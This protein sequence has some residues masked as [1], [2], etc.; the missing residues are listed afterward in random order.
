MGD[1]TKIEWCDHTFQPGWVGCAKVS[2]GCD[3]CYAEVGTTARVARGRGLQLWGPDATRQPMSEDYWKNPE[4]WFRAAVRDGV[5]RRVFCGSMADVFE[6]R[7]DLDEHRARL[8]ELIEATAAGVTTPA[9]LL[10][11]RGLGESALT[12]K[13]GLDWL[14]LT[15]RPEAVMRLIPEWWH[16]GLPSN[17][18][19]GTS[20]ENQE[21][22]DERIPYLL[23][24][25][26]RVRF[27]SLEPLLGPVVGLS[28]YLVDDLSRMG[29]AGNR[30]E[31]DWMI[32]GGESG[33]KARP[34]NVAWVRDLV[35]QGHDAGVPVFVKQLGAQVFWDG[36]SDPGQ[37][38]P[39]DVEARSTTRGLRGFSAGG[40]HMVL[41]DRKGGDPAEW[42]E[43]LR[44]REFPGA[45]ATEPA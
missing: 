24:V 5:R 16:A 39:G 7:R 6:D 33:P 21:A 20:V 14:L 11:F 17:V 38:W 18:W 3:H 25:P 9:G 31:I 43:D 32:I 36:M 4:R 12:D 15:K 8:W 28:P 42:P 37:H 35:W 13:G 1:T 30:M 41:S 2:A 44:V 40:W 19:V 22:A 29:C 26:A 34:C 45:P 10:A 23:R 27:L